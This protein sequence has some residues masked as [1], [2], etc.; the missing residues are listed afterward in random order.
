MAAAELLWL[1]A[2]CE[3]G[4]CVEIAFEG[5]RVHLRSSGDPAGT[6]LVSRAEWDAF[7]EAVRNNEVETA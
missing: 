2:K 3:A 5:E 7:A 4:A 1:K 6:I